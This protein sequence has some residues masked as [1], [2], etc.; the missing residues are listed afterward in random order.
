MDKILSAI[1]HI[2]S[3]GI[4]HRDIK[5]DNI[6]FL[7]K[8]IDSEIKIIDFGLS[9]KCNEGKDLSTIVGTPLYVSPDVLRGRYNE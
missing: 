2:H 4:V 6:L 3:K 7:T 8:Q 1:N 5:P 9:V